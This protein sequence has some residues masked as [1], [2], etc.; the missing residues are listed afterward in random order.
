[1]R[2]QLT[3]RRFALLTT[4]PILGLAGCS[5]PGGEDGGS[6]EGEKEEGEDEEEDE[7]GYALGSR[8]E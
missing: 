5:G 7:G 6:E 2:E 4:V 3:R 8:A 1:M